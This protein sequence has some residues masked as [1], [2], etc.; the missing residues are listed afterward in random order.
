M[1]LNL[2]LGKSAANLTPIPQMTIKTAKTFIEKLSSIT[3]FG[4]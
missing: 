1:D 3:P 4:H 2:H